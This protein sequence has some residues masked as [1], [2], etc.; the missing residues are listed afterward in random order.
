[1][2]SQAKLRIGTR[3]SPLALAQA[4]EVRD[5]LVAAHDDLGAESVEV[6]EFTTSGDRIIDRPL[7]EIGGKGLFTKEIEEALSAGNI[8]V[9]VH[10]LKDVPTVLPDGLAIGC[11][12]E[13]ADPRDAFISPVAAT[14]DALPDGAV[15]GTSSLRRRAQ[16]LNR[17]PTLQVADFR[18]N[19]GTR[20]RKLGDGLADAT[21]LAVAGLQRLGIAATVTSIIEPEE[22]L[23]AVGQGAIAL[24]V[25]SG[26]ELTAARLAPLNH[27][28]TAACVAAERALLA[29]LDGSCRTPIA[30]LAEIAA[31]GTLALRAAV[32]TPDGAKAWR[33]DRQ[34][35]PAD[36]AVLGGD[37]GNELKARAGPEFLDWLS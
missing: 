13:R 3:R 37:A 2:I 9:A 1:M 33:T 19:V 11:I 32:F 36:A 21:L 15:V 26:D 5:L 34:G 10:S 4:A 7:A 20:L 27:P 6:V 24:E 18:G 23:P 12:L 28:E 8:D 35:A 25:R 14:L 17:H 30:A 31:D 29:A 22:L 16:V